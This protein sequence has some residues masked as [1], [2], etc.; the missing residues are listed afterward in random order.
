MS[1]KLDCVFKHTNSTTKI[2]TLKCGNSTLLAWWYCGVN[3][4]KH[5]QS[6]PLA[7]VAFRKQING[8][9]FSDEIVFR[10]IPIVL[11]GQIRIGSLCRDDRVIALASFETKE[12]K[13]LHERGEWWFTSFHKAAENNRQPPYP[14]NIYPLKYELD[15][16]WLIEFKLSNS[17]TLLV[18]SLEYFTRCYGQSGELRRILTT[19]QW[20]GQ[21]GCLDRFFA[22][23]DEPES[24]TVWKIKLRKRLYNGDTVFLAHVKYD[25]Y[26]RKVA[27]GIYSDLDVQYTGESYTPA[28][29]RIGPWF[30]GKAQ[31]LVGGIP[32]NNGK[33]FLAL[34]IHGVSEPLGTDIE[35]NRD[36][37]NN[38]LSPAGPEAEGN[39]W[40]GAP[41][42]IPNH[43]P[44]IINLTSDDSPDTKSDTLDLNDP[45]LVIL[46]KRR[47]IRNHRDKQAEDSS[48]SSGKSKDNDTF[49]VGETH[50]DGKNIGRANVSTETI[51]E[52]E[53]ALRD[54]WN[55]IIHLKKN[56]PDIVKS[57]EWYTLSHGYI[58]N[59]E[60]ELV[61][62]EAFG[63]NETFDNET[64]P[65]SIMKWP[66]M[67]PK[68]LTEP[69]GLLVTRINVAGKYIHIIEIQRRPLKYKDKKSGVILEG[70]ERFCGLVFILNNENEFNSWFR[71]VRSNVRKV[72]GVVQ[73]LVAYCPGKADFFKHST[74]SSDD[75]P[76]WSALKNAL[77]KMDIHLNK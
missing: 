22:P 32:F 26:T 47:V 3:K 64:I 20:D 71:F 75:V 12:F 56:Y 15:K 33:S 10:S 67:D 31:L 11:L 7:L 66:F 5:D 37:R 50:G 59:E 58:E 40:A 27:K 68:T 38:A 16:N 62:L 60:P 17:G 42:K 9:I 45:K 23:I 49:S 1:V 65:T 74:A 8:N 2:D 18:P 4:N 70:E 61:A 21:E 39:A 19:Y 48:G 28:F 51:M 43:R 34:Q 52:S 25:N 35:K 29:P 41:V 30:T 46:G 55:A 13:L 54:I 63:K 76:C 57:V 44:E 73:K 14:Q 72:T 36:N 6:Q 69:R 24:D 53:G 77:N